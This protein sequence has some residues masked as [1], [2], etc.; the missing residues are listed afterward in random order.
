MLRLAVFTFLIARCL[1]ST[2]VSA[3]KNRLSTIAATG[4][5]LLLAGLWT[6]ISSAVTA[7]L[8]FG[9]AIET[10]DDRAAHFL[11]AAITLSLTVLGPGAW[12]VDARLFG[13]RRISITED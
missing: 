13:R 12:S 3:D 10:G 5:L 8:E 7:L 4:G 2:T 11:A 6:P 9:I 1:S